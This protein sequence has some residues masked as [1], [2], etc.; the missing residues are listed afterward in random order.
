[1]VDQVALQKQYD[2]VHAMFTL[3]LRKTVS[4]GLCLCVYLFIC[5]FLCLWLSVY[6]N[7]KKV[8][9]VPL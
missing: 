3:Y 6:L 9:W 1:M 2:S 5:T 7:I 4:M 8:S